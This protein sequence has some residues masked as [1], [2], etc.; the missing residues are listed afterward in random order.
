[1]AD[2]ARKPERPAA[3][4]G[5][6]QQRP[7]LAVV[8]AQQ[9]DRLPAAAGEDTQPGVGP[10]GRAEDVA[11]ALGERRPVGPSRVDVREE[12]DRLSLLA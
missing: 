5:Q 9:R 12:L 6:R 2:E 10:F 7:G 3:T 11:G 8:Q 1:M 4:D